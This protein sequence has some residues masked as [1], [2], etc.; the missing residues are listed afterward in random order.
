MAMGAFLY[1]LFWLIGLGLSV[2]LLFSCCAYHISIP[3]LHAV[4][5]LSIAVPWLV[6]ANLFYLLIWALGRKPVSLVPLSALLAALISFGFP[7]IV[8]PLPAAGKGDGLKVMSYNVRG[9]NATKQ[10]EPR[11]AGEKIVALVQE[12]DPDIVCFQEFNSTYARDFEYFRD[13]FITPAATGKTSQAIYSKFPIVKVGSIAFPGSNNNAIFADILY[14]KDTLRIYNIHMES[15]KIR[16]LRLLFRNYGWDFFMLFNAV[17]EKH[18][19]QAGLVRDHLAASQYPTLLCGDF[20]ATAF[21]RPYRIISKGLQDSFRE[22]G[23]GWGATYFL[24]QILRMRIDFVLASDELEFMNH[25][26]REERLS[27][28]LPVV[29]TLK[30]KAD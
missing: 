22:K 27:D 6:L 14:Q 23:A 29:A 17:A 26:I 18:R 12:E 20:N 2:L 15:Y 7:R 11:N 30:A 19:E 13:W 3:A 1:R 25:R 21:S 5:S 16:S 24:K 9:F 8:S 28:H 4:D 10:Y